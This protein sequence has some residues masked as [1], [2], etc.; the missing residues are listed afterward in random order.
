MRSRLAKPSRDLRIINV[1]S[2][3]LIFLNLVYILIL[4]F[5]EL[6]LLRFFSVIFRNLKLIKLFIEFSFV[7]FPFRLRVDI[8]FIFVVV[9]FISGVL[10]VIVIVRVDGVEFIKHLFCDI[11]RI[12]YPKLYIFCRIRAQVAVEMILFDS[13]SIPFCLFSCHSYKLLSFSTPSKH[14]D[15]LIVFG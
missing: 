10:V 13:L 11:L 2:K 4:L 9:E 8:Y 1:P 5:I 7:A 6:L 12:C 15:S 14:S 3:V